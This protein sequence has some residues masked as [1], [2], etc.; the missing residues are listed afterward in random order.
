ML[1]S[2][3][4]CLLVLR[5]LL[6]RAVGLGP[7]HGVG[8]ND[9]ARSTRG[10][11]D[12]GA[13]GAWVTLGTVGMVRRTGLVV[14]MVNTNLSSLIL[15]GAEKTNPP[16]LPLSE[17]RP[18]DRRTYHA[19]PPASGEPLIEWLPQELLTIILNLAC[20]K[21]QEVDTF[22]FVRSIS[23]FS[24]VNKRWHATMIDPLLSQPILL[25]KSHIS[26]F[27]NAIIPFERH[28]LAVKD[29]RLDLR[30]QEQSVAARALLTHLCNLRELEITYWHVPTIKIPPLRRLV[31]LKLFCI[32]DDYEIPC[33]HDLVECLPSLQCLKFLQTSGISF[34]TAE[35]D[36]PLK[37]LRKLHLSLIPM[38]ISHEGDLQWRTARASDAILPERHQGYHHFFIPPP[39]MD[40]SPSI[41]SLTLSDAVFASPVNFLDFIFA[42]KDTLA[43]LS[44]M[45]GHVATFPKMPRLEYLEYNNIWGF[46]GRATRDL[47]EAFP[48]IGSCATL[49]GLKLFGSV[50]SPSAPTP[51]FSLQY[52]AFQDEVI[53][54]HS[55]FHTLSSSH[56][57]LEIL[58]VGNWRAYLDPLLPLLP[59]LRILNLTLRVPE[60]R[61]DPTFLSNL[62]SLICLALSQS[63]GTSVEWNSAI[64]PLPHLEY[65]WV[66]GQTYFDATAQLVT[67]DVNTLPKLKG[68][69]FDGV[70]DHK[71]LQWGDREILVIDRKSKLAEEWDLITDY[72]PSSWDASD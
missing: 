60:D 14:M 20:C 21:S 61:P 55:V 34:P 29:L 38:H 67:L 19:L 1:S 22:S 64:P 6:K 69:V 63:Q 46:R 48:H 51:T 70:G 16:A 39:M 9:E 23:P 4:L 3:L 8:L 37:N 42:F 40:S 30:P 57:S 45:A 68:V 32:L 44:L 26:V 13:D 10:T 59:A 72:F 24:L 65:L 71:C 58:E 28:C 18:K 25:R 43:H 66:M 12:V 33:L 36:R 47:Y 56:R 62:P 5:R 54:A 2:F 41:R 17:R 52:L 11:T 50:I 35:A 7:S 53:D 31:R 15:D 49:K 27:Y